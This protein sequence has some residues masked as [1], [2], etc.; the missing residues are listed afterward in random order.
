MPRPRNHGVLR[1]VR[2]TVSPGSSNARSVY[3]CSVRDFAAQCARIL[4]GAEEFAR[5]PAEIEDMSL[6]S[7]DPHA[8]RGLEE[9][10]DD[11]IPF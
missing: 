6:A 3:L 10:D 11:D 2:F 1:L 8:V 5:E 9:L 7:D 4:E